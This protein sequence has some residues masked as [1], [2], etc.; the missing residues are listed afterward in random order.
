MDTPDLTLEQRRLGA[1]K[2]RE[3]LEAL[4]QDPTLSQDRAKAIRE[5]LARIDAW[6]AGNLPED[7]RS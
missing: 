6:E 5:Q 3:Q 2:M 1:A 7:I 4:L